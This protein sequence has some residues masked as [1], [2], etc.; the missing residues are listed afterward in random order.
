MFVVIICVNCDGSSQVEETDI[1]K[2]VQCPRC[3]KPT[4]ARTAEAVLPVAKSI[5]ES[6]ISLDDAAPLPPKD[7]PPAPNFE[8]STGPRQ[9]RP[10]L[11]TAVYAGASILLTL[12]AMALTYGAFRYGSGEIPSRA[13]TKFTPPDGK[14]SVDLPGEPEVEEIPAGRGGM[15]GGKRFVVNRWFERVQLT[16]GWIDLDADKWLGF[17]F[18]QVVAPIRDDEAKWLGGSI[19]GEASVNFVVGKRKFEA[20]L[21]QLDTREGKGALQIYFD[22]DSSHLAFHDVEGTVEQE[23]LMFVPLM[24]GTGGIW[25]PIEAPV[26]VQKRV[27]EP[28]QRFRIW[29][30]SVSGKKINSETKWLPRFFNSFIPD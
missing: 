20:R 2:V 3:G 21:Y 14:C 13:W 10:P 22:S 25:L 24:H 27:L 9:K 26:N 11:R 4:I 1:G 5:Q 8:S 30:A 19:T 15:L 17:K 28:G 12:L 23:F 18:D 7:E 16:F 29:F 6:P